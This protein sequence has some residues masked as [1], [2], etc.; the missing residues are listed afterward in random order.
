MPSFHPVRAALLLSLPLRLFLF[1]S[2]G[3]EKLG[4]AQWVCSVLA[5]ILCALLRS[6]KRPVRAV[7]LG[8]PSDR[9][10]AFF[11][12]RSLFTVSVG[13][14]LLLFGQ[15]HSSYPFGLVFGLLLPLLE[16]LCHLR[17]RSPCPLLGWLLAGL[18]CWGLTDVL[19][20]L[21]SPS[22]FIALCCMA[23]GC[24]LQWVIG[25]MLSPQSARDTFPFIGR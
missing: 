4:K 14:F 7:S 12:L 1:L 21:K 10:T 13:V 17:P 18:C 5:L 16:A 3:S 20:G 22:L 24:F 2:F 6:L 15:T 25:W 9:V 23:V 8:C 19:Y 11:L